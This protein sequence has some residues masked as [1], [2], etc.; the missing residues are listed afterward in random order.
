MANKV[1][2]PQ[3]FFDEW[4]RTSEEYHPPLTQFCNCQALKDAGTAK[5]FPDPSTICVNCTVSVSAYNA[6]IQK[7]TV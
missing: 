4:L 1:V 7:D 5:L 6:T 3:V 2:D